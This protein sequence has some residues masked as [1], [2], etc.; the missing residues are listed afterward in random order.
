V[1][2]VHPIQVFGPKWDLTPIG[3]AAEHVP[4][5]VDQQCVNCTLGFT[6]DMSGVF[7]YHAADEDPG[8]KPWH[9][10]CFI[11]NIMGPGLRGNYDGGMPT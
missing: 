6:P 9:R 1:V 4:V 10:L 2:I 11:F 7:V 3:E 8:Y 5:P